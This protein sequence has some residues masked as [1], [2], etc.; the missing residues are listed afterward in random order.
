VE[1]SSEGYDDNSG[2]A[3]GHD[4]G[5]PPPIRSLRFSGFFLS[6]FIWVRHLISREYFLGSLFE[7]RTNRWREQKLKGRSLIQVPPIRFKKR[8]LGSKGRK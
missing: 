7:D 1:A 2:E 3:V 5:W 6:L 8:S 4:F